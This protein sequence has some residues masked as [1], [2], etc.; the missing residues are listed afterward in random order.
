MR[1]TRAA[2]NSVISVSDIN[3]TAKMVRSSEVNKALN[4]F[5]NSTQCKMQAKLHSKVNE[6]ADVMVG[7]RNR[8]WDQGGSQ[9]G[10]T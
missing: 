4:E 2:A 1:K 7:P 9:L 5:R 10:C 3:T 8:K 6:N